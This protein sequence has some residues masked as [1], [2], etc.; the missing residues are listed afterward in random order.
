MEQ[1]IQSHGQD[2]LPIVKESHI[3]IQNLSLL[4]IEKPITWTQ[5]QIDNHGNPI[6]GTGYLEDADGKPVS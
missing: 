6:P 5:P 2:L 3:Q 1:V 4:R